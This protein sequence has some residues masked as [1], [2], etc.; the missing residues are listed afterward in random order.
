V[1]EHTPGPWEL[2]RCREQG[3]E[4]W[5]IGAREGDTAVVTVSGYTGC[6]NGPGLRHMDTAENDANA[7]LIASA[8]D[9]LEALKS[10]SHDGFGR[11]LGD[12]PAIEAAIAKA[13]G[14]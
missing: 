7:R 2:D 13:E 8:P 3:R 12:W 1:N 10:L 11:V 9:L 6:I 14:R 5:Q 4:V